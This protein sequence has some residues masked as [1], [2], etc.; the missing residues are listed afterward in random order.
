MKRKK[1][2]HQGDGQSIHVHRGDQTAKT[3]HC[4]L[5]WSTIKGRR[6]SAEPLYSCHERSDCKARLDDQAQGAGWAT[7]TGS[8]FTRFGALQL[9]FR[10]N[11]ES[12]AHRSSVASI[13]EGCLNGKAMPTKR[14]MWGL[15]LDDGLSRKTWMPARLLHLVYR[16]ASSGGTDSGPYGPCKGLS[17]KT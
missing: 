4:P 7:P 3:R 8:C 13:C 6:R 12:P 11:D 5:G 15:S 1:Q 10:L 2:R 14:D 9:G 17:G 16:P